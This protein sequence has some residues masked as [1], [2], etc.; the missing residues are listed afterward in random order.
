[1]V[2]GVASSDRNLVHMIDERC[3]SL[4]TTA[5]GRRFFFKSGVR[6]SR[7]LAPYAPVKRFLFEK[8]SFELVIVILVN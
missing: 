3:Q 2:L 8:V 4:K 5:Y 6:N 7:N 1:M